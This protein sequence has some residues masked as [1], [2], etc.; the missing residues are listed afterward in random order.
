[1]HEVSKNLFIGL[2]GESE[3]ATIATIAGHGKLDFIVKR[4][5][6]HL[7]MTVKQ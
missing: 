3:L 7:F 6:A 4:Q 1:V 2:G 5:H